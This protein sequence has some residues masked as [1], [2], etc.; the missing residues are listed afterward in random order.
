MFDFLGLNTQRANQEDSYETSENTED[1]IRNTL[2][3]IIAETGHEADKTE[4]NCNNVCYDLKLNLPES[5]NVEIISGNFDNFEEL[6]DRNDFPT[7]HTF[8]IVGL[9][10]EYYLVDPTIGQFT[11]NA[12]IFV[13]QISGGNKNRCCQALQGL[14]LPRYVL[15]LYLY[16]I[17]DEK[18]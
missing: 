2:E 5:W 13:H 14:N 7:H 18:Y 4:D 16:T 9:G 1:I 17:T 12:E 15:N 11:G 8:L 6:I 3:K 10:G